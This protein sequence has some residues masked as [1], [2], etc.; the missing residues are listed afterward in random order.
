[1]TLPS[2]FVSYSHR[3]EKWKDL[4]K[5]H[6][7]M[8]EQAN[9]L[10]I[11]D[12]RKI[13][14]GD[15]WYDEIK[16]AMEDAEVAV[17]LIS[18]DYL[19]SDFCV[20]E[21]IPYLLERR[22]NNGLVLIPILIRPCAWKAIDW[23]KAIQMLPRDGKSVAVDFKDDPDTPFTQVAE[24]I[25]SLDTGVAFRR[26]LGVAI[27]IPRWPQPERVDV[28]RLPVTGQELFGR[29]KELKQLDEAWA[30]E[31]INVISF[32]AYGGVGKSTLINKWREQMAAE[33]YRGAKRVYA[34]SFYS[35]GTGDRVTSADLF[36]AEALKWFGDPEMANSPASPWDKG[37]RLAD[38]VKEQKTLLL[39]DGMEPLQSYFEFER[40][41]IKDPAL[42][43]LVTELAKENPGL[44]VITTRENVI[45]LADFPE[46]TQQIDFEQISAEAGRAILRVGGVRGT[47]AELEEAAR[48][49]GLHALALSLLA[50]YIHEIPGHHISNAKDIPDIDV[51]EKEGKHPRRVI[52]AFEKKFGDSAEVNVLRILGLFRSPAENEEI[53][54]VR[55]APAIPSLTEHLQTISAVKWLQV[56][57]KLRRLKLIQPESIHRP[58]A[59]DAHPLVRE[60]F[61]KQ[62][63]QEY[64]EAWREGNS[65]LYEYYKSTAKGLPDT[66]EEMAPLFSAVRHGCQ[67]GLH[68]EAFWEYYNRIQRNGRIGYCSKQLGA[69]GADLATIS[70]F[71]DDTSWHQPSEGLS[72]DMRAFILSQAGFCLRA[73]GRLI[74]AVQPFQASLKEFITQMVWK[75][76]VKQASN[77]SELYLAIGDIRQ[78]LDYMEQANDFA[79]KSEDIIAKLLG[80]T[81]LAYALHQSGDIT[82]AK[83][84]FRSAEE[85]QKK[86]FPQ[87]R[88]LIM[89]IAGFYFCDLLLDQEMYDEVQRR[90]A[91][92][93]LEAPEEIG[94]LLTIALDNLAFGR[95][96]LIQSQHEPDHAFAESLTHLNQAV[97]GLRQAGIQYHLPRGLLA[98]AEYYRATGDIQRAQRDLDEAFTL[99]T[100]GG[101]GLY[102]ADCHLEYA[103]LSLRARRAKQS[104]NNEGIASSHASSTGQESAVPPLSA[105]LLA[106][107]DEELKSKA[108]EHWQIAK[109]SIEKMGYHRRDKEVQELE[110]QLK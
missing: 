110:E 1:M 42:A 59:L 6:L 81:R 65:R 88:F 15:T 54:A 87:F 36:I 27:E 57:S 71:F 47:D 99:A 83:D 74:E 58:E 90:R 93:Y 55:D 3:D 79:D 51:P 20:K 80:A 43:V 98:R 103:R 66:L 9:R 25:L 63:R 76:A 102:L 28:D 75:Q 19:A 24:R 52:A 67:A 82:K 11:W 16:T 17:C 101:M 61:G 108:R 70:G 84:L 22:K 89:N 106:M 26:E 50:S 109:D 72:E 92:Q 60:H 30:S 64:P 48:D 33:N 23:L 100:R 56:V 94:D 78:A 46:T 69:F 34:W 77:L 97:N 95:A 10:T 62:L 68:R 45:D 29:Q 4:L 35:Q 85:L 21:E 12:D 73:L 8:L 38:L 40:G 39:L 41:K 37:Q 18:A 5:P 44:C 107:T 7:R 96:H 91:R 31:S 86:F 105:K 49:F 2:V 53:A 14:A 32:V 13:D 104:P